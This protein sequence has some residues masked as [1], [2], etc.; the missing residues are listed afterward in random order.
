MA[1][2]EKTIPADKGRAEDTVVYGKREKVAEE[3]SSDRKRECMGSPAVCLHMFMSG[4]G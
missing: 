2:V 1:G 4:R 3:G